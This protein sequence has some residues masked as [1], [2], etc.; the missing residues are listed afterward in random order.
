MDNDTGS[1]RLRAGLYA[2]VSTRHGQDVNLQ[3]D[4]LQRVADQRGWE[5][6][7]YVDE[8]ISG[9]KDS[10][11]ALDRMLTDARAGKL[12]IIAVWRFDRYGRSLQHLVRSLAEFDS[13]GIEFLSITESIDTGSPMGRV[14][15]N[16][17][18]SL[19]QFE[20]ELT[21]ERIAAGMAKA[22]RD[23]KQ[24]GRP[25]KK[26]DMD[27]VLR[28]QKSGMPMCEIARFL[29]VPRSTIRSRIRRAKAAGSKG[30]T[31]S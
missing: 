4:D 19:A 1:K 27:R 7:E 26:L 3:L 14:V 18:G 28:L 2:R 23:G 30:A 16:I 20:V 5:S 12:D 13:L 17:M 24:I 8:G 10:R 9:S 11:P 25:K 15:F 21:R 6:V 22:R 31:N 29:D